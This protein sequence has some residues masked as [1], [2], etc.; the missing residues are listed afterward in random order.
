MSKLLSE[1][2]KTKVYNNY[3]F[4][5]KH[6]YDLCLILWI[7]EILNTYQGCRKRVGWGGTFSPPSTT[8]P[9]GFSDLA[10]ALRHISSI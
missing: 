8:S 3:I 10:T 2:I 7:G 6:M 9:L 4:M 1:T 5:K